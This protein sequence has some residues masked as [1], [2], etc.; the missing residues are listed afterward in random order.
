MFL[1]VVSE[2]IIAIHSNKFGFAYCTLRNIHKDKTIRNQRY[3]EEEI[4][5]RFISR[6][7]YNGYRNA[8]IS[9]TLS[10]ELLC[11]S[12]V[13]PVSSSPR[14][15]YC[16]TVYTGFTVKLGISVGG[17]YPEVKDV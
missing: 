17:K 12:L 10:M 5:Q 14:L 9:F 7:V 3:E 11:V 6:Q 16:Q 2:W 8:R 4:S 15:V 1:I 13:P